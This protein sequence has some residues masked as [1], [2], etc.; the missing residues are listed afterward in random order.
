MNIVIGPDKFKGS[1]SA[2]EVAEAICDG[3]RSVFPEATIRCIPIADG[4]E[5]TAEILKDA[6][7]GSW[8]TVSV[9]DPLG[10][11]IEARYCWSE[12]NPRAPVA[13]IEMSEASGMKRLKE[14]ELDPLRANTFGTG[15]LILA[16]TAR[17]ARKIIV[18]LGG[19]ATND[20]GIGMA[21]AL[22]FQFIDQEGQQ[23]EPI[24]ANLDK[25]A[26]I[27]PPVGLEL[28]EILA[29]VDVSNPL[30]GSEGATA[31]FGPQKGADSRRLEQLEKGLTNLAEIVERD[32]SV[33]AQEMKGGGAAGGLGF[34]LVSFCGAK[35]TSGFELLA[36]A[37]D[38]EEAI[39]GADLVI[40]A[41]GKMEAQT[42]QG[43]GPAGV[44]ALARKHGK[45]VIGLAGSLSD[46]EKLDQAFDVVMPIISGPMD[47]ETAME[48]TALSLRRA[49]GRIARI[50]AIARA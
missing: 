35:I 17:G 8:E 6:F 24:P 19:S 7:D 28:P 22:G 38:L 32:L 25:I 5:G 10:R 50:Y 12:Q 21:A 13:V 43:K 49:A 44:A 30:L 26:Q 15:Q 31:V 9:C 23:L 20:G 36:K 18:G 11:E 4:G 16:A 39:G 3:F 34:G 46:E 14:T 2:S 1:L 42:L 41:E 45:P 33:V 48:N 40:T 47:L 27:K 29:A 37:V